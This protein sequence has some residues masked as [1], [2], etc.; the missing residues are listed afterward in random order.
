MVIKLNDPKFKHQIFNSWTYAGSMVSLRSNFCSFKGCCDTSKHLKFYF[1]L[2]ANNSFIVNAATVSK[3][4]VF[5]SYE[6]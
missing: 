1:S 4:N 2:K 5:A 3:K 6:S